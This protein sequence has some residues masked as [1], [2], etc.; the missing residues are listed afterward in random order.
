MRCNARQQNDSKTEIRNDEGGV[1]KMSRTQHHTGRKQKMEGRGRGRRG[2]RKKR[3]DRGQRGGQRG[4]KGESVQRKRKHS[5]R[6]SC[7]ARGGKCLTDGSS[8][9]HATS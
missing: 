1:I 5:Y 8:S 4:R 6:T 9:T 3:K 2:G 7:A